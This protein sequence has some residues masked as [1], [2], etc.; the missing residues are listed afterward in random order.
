M[1]GSHSRA[2]LKSSQ[3]RI[4]NAERSYSEP[5][6]SFCHRATASIHSMKSLERW[7]RDL[8][9]LRLST[10]GQF[11]LISPRHKTKLPVKKTSAMTLLSRNERKREHFTG[12]SSRYT[13]TQS[14]PLTNCL[15]TAARKHPSAFLNW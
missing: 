14:R 3:T 9:S 4:A 1:S 7:L 6:D 5:A 8:R 10:G 12:N 11:L 2:F 15:K 13:T